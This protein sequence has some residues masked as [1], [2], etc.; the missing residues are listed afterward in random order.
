MY[1]AKVLADSVHEDGHR[2]LLTVEVTFPRFI[3]AEVNTHRV[4]SRNSASSRA[5]PPEKQIARALDHPF[6]PDVFC[7]RIKGMGQGQPIAEQDKARA[8]WLLARD[9]A[10]AQ[11]T[12]LM[13]LGISKAHVNRILEPFMWHTAILTGEE[14]EN[15]FALRSPIGD[16][17]DLDFPAQ[18]EFQRTAIEMRKVMRA[19]SPRRLSE[20]DWHLPL[21]TADEVFKADLRSHSESSRREARIRLAKISAGRCARVSFDTQGEFEPQEA[22]IERAE[23][24]LKSGHL[25]PFEHPATPA[26]LGARGNFDSWAQYRS[27]IEHEWNLV[28]HLAGR[29][30]WEAIPDVG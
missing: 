19:S 20:A 29:P 22:S 27:V 4:L 21:V 16:E 15:F 17:V 30:G 28:G 5:I 1:A 2:R 3:L 25:S 11:A 14:W 13:A 24:L 18:P 12:Q 8:E 26:R 9:V 10:V 6:V 7:E 23:K